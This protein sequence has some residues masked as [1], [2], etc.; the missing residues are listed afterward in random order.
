MPRVQDAQIVL[1]PEDFRRR[2]FLL[3][4]LTWT[5]PPVFGL[6]FIL[7]L[8]IL[9]PAQM[10]ALMTHPLEPL[11][12][13]GWLIFALGYFTRYVRPFVTYLANPG[14]V[15]ET[16]ILHRLRRFPLHYW[17]WFLLYLLMA[18]TSVLIGAEMSSGHVATPLDWFRIHLVALIVSI[19]VGLPIFFLTLDLFGRALGGLSLRRPVVTI[20]TK[21]FLIGAL[22]PLLIDTILVQYYWTRT[23]FFTLETFFVWLS[24]EL[25]AIGG[26]LI[27]VRSFGQ[28]LR[29]LE[30]AIGT[31]RPEP[32]PASHLT[33]CSTD[34]LGVLTDGYRHLLNELR[35]RSEILDVANRVL[36]CAGESRALPDLL[37][38]VVEVAQEVLPG[39]MVFLI[40]KDPARDELV[41]V[42][43]TG[44]KYRAE[45]HFRLSLDEVSMAVNVFQQK[46][47]LAIDDVAR[48]PRVSP[49]MRAAFK[50][51]SAIGTPLL[52]DG[53]P[54]GVLM[55]ISR[56]HPV[57]YTRWDQMLLE[58]LAR[59]AA[60]A[61]HATRLREERNRLEQRQ[62]AQ[63]QALL[64]L[65]RAQA[66]AEEDPAAV[67]AETT[68]TVA[69]AMA[70][71]RVGIW[72]FNENRDVLICQDLFEAG[73]DRHGTG[74]VLK[75]SEYPD[76]FRALDEN[77]VIAASDAHQAPETRAFFARYLSPN[78]IG[79][80]L[81]APLR[82]GSRVSGVLCIEHVGGPR[83]WELDE[84]NFAASVADMTSLVLELW[85]HRQ[86]TEA[87]RRHQEL[88][89]ERVAERTEQ[90]L[91]DLRSPLRAIDGFSH[92][93]L[94]EYGDR[95]DATGVDYLERVRKAAQRMG[96]LIDALLKLSRLTRSE[97]HWQQVDLSALAGEIAGE[98]A[99]REPERDVH[100][101]IEPGLHAEGD[102][103]LLRA[104]LENLLGN[105]WKYTGQTPSPEIRLTR[106]DHEGLTAFCVSDNGAGF[107]MAHATK[108]FAPFHRLHSDAEFPGSGIGLATADR[109]VRR[110]GGRIWAQATPGEGAKFCFTLG[111]AETGKR[112]PAED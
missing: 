99:R 6:G 10:L 67:L 42:S 15:V 83:K 18:P 87:L 85:D 106:E 69:R 31:E 109:I 41:G 76:Y 84:Q 49:R 92:A 38:A 52:Q 75:A 107:D 61:I 64:T 57:H 94:E 80:M 14:T 25:L 72:L 23:G 34:E 108:L 78:G 11:F 5:I 50:V 81:D 22:V 40:L 66:A 68:E 86:T 110:H 73:S 112:D 93:L 102:P 65:S 27:F 71:A 12:I 44:A 19:I 53:E 2:F 32:D 77:R 56:E 91:H 55:S 30:G 79:A 1:A 98:L 104:L 43:Q 63:H 47:M 28:S 13:F 97:L 20:K 8:G 88:L 100:W 48:D 74:L 70:V 103:G 7:Y 24:L 89:E 35:V 17:G 111:R 39:D 45:G 54:I 4:L 3:I 82:R 26:S 58:S 95:L 62:Q 21:V 29:P 101:H 59:E 51:V 16:G 37:D 36:R 96:N 105:A 33:P 90:L 9:T 60:M 46:A